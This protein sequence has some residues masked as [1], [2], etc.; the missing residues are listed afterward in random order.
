MLDNIPTMV[1]TINTSMGIV[2]LPLV[3][4]DTV[5]VGT[6]HRVCKAPPKVAKYIS[7]EPLCLRFSVM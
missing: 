1:G 3:F 5:V 6:R 7:S 2:S 4:R